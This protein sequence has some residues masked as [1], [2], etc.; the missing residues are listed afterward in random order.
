[1]AEGANEG[2]EGEGAGTSADT[3]LLVPPGRRTTEDSAI[4]S[5]LGEEIS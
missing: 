4:S 1:M 3:E 5:M 2:E